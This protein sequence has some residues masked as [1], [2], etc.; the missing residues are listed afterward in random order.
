ME[1]NEVPWEFYAE[2]TPNPASMKFVAS[3]NIIENGATAEYHK[4][5]ATKGAPLVQKLFEFPFTK[6]VFVSANY[7]TIT[8]HDFI[9]WPDVFQEVRSFLT[10]YTRSDK[11]LILELPKKD[12][13]VDSDF[14][15]TTSISTE[16]SIPKNEI[17]SKI[18]ETLESYIRPAVE[19][20]GGLIT[21]KSF[22]N[23]VV[24][25]QMK[26]ACSGCPSS[27]M[28]LK[29]GIENLLKR[30]IGDDIKEVVSEAV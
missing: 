21:F 27:T 10:T 28:T 4:I 5:T 8:K 19:Q 13:P 16:H 24:T 23:G 17:E 18:V 22:E 20:D 2:S 15:K 14:Q 12:F 6:S 26:G 7:I 11:P 3:K 1:T 9:E 29:A 25:V 30:V